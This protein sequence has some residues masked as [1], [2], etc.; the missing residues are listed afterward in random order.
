M[1]R[2]QFLDFCLPS[3]HK[4]ECREYVLKADLG[5]VPACLVLPTG[6]EHNPFCLFPAGCRDEVRWHWEV[7]PIVL[8]LNFLV[9]ARL[10]MAL[11]GGM[12]L[13]VHSFCCRSC[14]SFLVLDFIPKGC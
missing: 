6:R 10:C 2:H 9:P 12:E 8:T 13:S 7:P 1:K 5:D 3:G 4:A 14:S 11:A